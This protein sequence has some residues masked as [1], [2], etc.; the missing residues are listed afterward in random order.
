MILHI[1]TFKETYGEGYAAGLSLSSLT[2]GEIKNVDF[3]PV[4]LTYYPEYTG[5]Y[6]KYHAIFY[7][8]PFFPTQKILKDM[9]K[10]FII[11]IKEQ[12]KTTDM[13]SYREVSFISSTKERLMDRCTYKRDGIEPAEY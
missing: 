3:R 2:N 6:V 10:K 8:M 4:F 9:A 13:Y 7:I 11:L 1:P 5:H 12:Y